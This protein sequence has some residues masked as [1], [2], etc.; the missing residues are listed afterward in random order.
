MATVQSKMA[1]AQSNGGLSSTDAT[2]IA[3]EYSK[4][5]STQVALATRA[6][7]LEKKS[8]RRSTPQ[9]TSTLSVTSTA[10]PTPTPTP[11]AIQNDDPAYFI[12]HYYDEINNRNYEKT[13]D[14]LSKPFQKEKSGTF[15]RYIAWWD[16]IEKVD[17]GDI[18]ILS[19]NDTKAEV[20]VVIHY[21]KKDGSKST[22][23]TTFTL[24]SDAQNGW[25]ID[26]SK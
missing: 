25:L 19:Q 17:L 24:I 7:N 13:W 10:T 16:T 18:T 14:M 22:S 6:A 9:P 3:E 2:A 26:Q 20:K 15:E 12:Q 23:T 21:Y 5:K 11:T 1:T 4:L 8:A